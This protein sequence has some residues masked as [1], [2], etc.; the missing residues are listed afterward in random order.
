MASG[1]EPALRQQLI[2]ARKN[3]IVQLDELNFRARRDGR[4][5]R[6]APPDYRSVI[7]ELEEQLRD[8]DILLKDHGE[9]NA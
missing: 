4:T 2:E 9:R 8:I 1:K 6:D 7:A 3:I 5:S